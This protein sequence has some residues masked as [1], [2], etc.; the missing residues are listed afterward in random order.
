MPKLERRHAQELE[1]E[2]FT[3]W[4]IEKIRKALIRYRYMKGRNGRPM[5]WLDVLT[6]ILFC[7]E[8]HNEH[9]YDGES[10]FKEETLR[11]FAK[12]ESLLVADKLL[13]VKIFL[14]KEKVLTDN[15][16][17]EGR[18]NVENIVTVCLCL[19][20]FSDSVKNHFLGI[21]KQYKAKLRADDMSRDIELLTYPDSSKLF[22]RA[23]EK[24]VQKYDEGAG[25][26]SAKDDFIES[27]TI[28]E[29]FGFVAAN[30]LIH[31][32]LWGDDPEDQITYLEV[33]S[34]DEDNFLSEINFICLGESL[35]SLW[36]D[37]SD[38]NS[39]GDFRVQYVLGQDTGDMDE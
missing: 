33:N 38:F 36:N 8:T 19:S 30:N 12:K 7:P 37:G 11:R 28:R 32:F 25:F 18:M 21:G 29:G 14:V 2:K 23:K 20:S 31:I 4:Q 24:T 26:A 34:Y 16:L 17:N 10:K 15:D 13:D 35:A 3:D 27:A 6:K 22:F 9:D 5:S 39:P 1:I